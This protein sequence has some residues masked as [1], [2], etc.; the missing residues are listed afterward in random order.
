MPGIPVWRGSAMNKTD[1]T[2][3]TQRTYSLPT[4]KQVKMVENPESKNKAREG[5]ESL[6]DKMAREVSDQ[7]VWSERL[8]EVRERI[9]QGPGRGMFREEEE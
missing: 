2:P 3:C 8:T 6:G 7:V 5:K 4:G 9:R 1:Q